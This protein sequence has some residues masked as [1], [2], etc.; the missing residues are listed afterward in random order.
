MSTPPSQA[1]YRVSDIDGL[2]PVLAPAS[3]KRDRIRA[4]VVASAAKLFPI[5]AT[6]FTVTA[7]DI[8]IK[9]SRFRTKDVKSAFMEQRSLT[10]PL[11]A[12]LKITRNDTGETVEE[13]KVTLGHV[14]YLTDEHTFVVDGTRYILSNQLRVRPGAYTRFR[15][16]GELESAFNT[17]KGAS[18]KL[19]ID[20]STGVFYLQFKTTK[21]LLLPVLLALG[22]NDGHIISSWGKGVVE[23]NVRAGTGK[24]LAAL[25]VVA[26][27][28]SPPHAQP[29]PGATREELIAIIKDRWGRAVISPDITQTTLGEAFDHIS[30][31]ALISAG[32][33][34][35]DVYNGRAPEDDRDDVQF[36]TFHMPDTYFKERIEKNLAKSQLGI[37]RTKL[38]RTSQPTIS[39]LGVSGSITAPL[40]SLLTGS[41][42]AQ[43]P[44]QINPL[45][46]IDGA[47]KVTRLGEGGI[48]D[49][50]A[51]NESTRE[52]HDSHLGI[53]DSV[54]TPESGNVGVDVRAA[55]Y[56]SVDERGRMHGV[57]VNA[58]TGQTERVPV[59]VLRR[60][61]IG[62][63]DTDMTKPRVAVLHGDR[64]EEVKPSEVDY[65]CP[66]HIATISPATAFV[67]LPGN[68]QGNR[69]VMGAKQATQA[70]PLVNREEP[71][72]Q[73][74]LG[75]GTSAEKSFAKWHLPVAPAS[76][77]V[78]KIDTAETQIHIKGDDGQMYDVDYADNY[79]LASKTR[80]HHELSVKV[81]D[82]VK[83]DQILGESNF[84]RNGTMALGTNLRTAFLA[85]HGLNSNDAVVISESAANHKLVSEHAYRESLWIG[86]DTTIDKAKHRQYY[87]A[88][89]SPQQYDRLGDDGVIRVGQKVGTGEL[90]VAALTKRQPTADDIMLGRLGRQLT[91]PFKDAALVWDHGHEG[92]VTDVART[93]KGIAVLVM[94]R[95]PMAVGDKLSGRVGNKGVVSKI[96]PDNLMPRGED[97]KPMELLITSAAVVSRI[98]PS[99]VI[100]RAAAKAAQKLGTTV[101]AP[102]YTG[103][104]AAAWARDLQ[105]KAGVKDKE[106]LFDPVTGKSIEKIATGP[107]YVY[108]LFKSTETNF[109]T[110]G[111]GPGYDQNEQPTK[112]GVAGAKSLG[113]MDMLALVAHDARGILSEAATVKGQAND[114]YW[115]NLQLGLPPGPPK[116]SFA[117][118]KFESMLVGAGVD[119]K[120]RGSK[121]QLGPLTD[122]D[123]DR[124]ADHEISNPGVVQV[125]NTKEGV[126][127]VPEKGGLFDPVTTGGLRGT[128]WGKVTLAEVTI[129]PVFETAAKRILDMDTRTFEDILYNQGGQVLKD[130]LNAVD[131][132]ALE[133]TLSA[134]LKQD[135]GKRPEAHVDKIAKRLK[136]VRALLSLGKK[137]GDA[138]M[139][140]KIPVVPP[141]MRGIVQGQGQTLLV[142]DP[143]FLY[144][145][146]M[147]VNDAFK[148]QPAELKEALGSSASRR[149]LQQAV[150]ALVGTGDPVNAKTQARQVQGFL[151][152]VAGVRT[153]KEGFVQSRLIKRRQDLSGRGTIAPDPNLGIDEI[154]IPEEMLWTQMRPFVMR[155]LVNRGYDALAAEKMIQEHHPTARQELMLETQ[156]RPVM[157][158]RAPTLHRY[159]FVAGWA[160]PVPGKTI[161]LSPFYEQLGNADYD[162]DAIQIHVPVTD[163][164]VS[165]AKRMTISNLALS[166]GSKNSVIAAPQH[167]AIIGTFLA[168]EKATDKPA[169]TFDSKASAMKAYYANK[170]KINDPIVVRSPTDSVIT[171]IPSEL[172]SA[173]S[174]H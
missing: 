83:K 125:K 4:Q 41:A 27:K 70:V 140:S 84:T 166:D 148:N 18:F 31:D 8:A 109:A 128:R 151:S 17:D 117:Y 114:T 174:K 36:Q 172:T 171:P 97:G 122:S 33:K 76:G 149:E 38:N 7:S 2:A 44:A 103:V 85:Y 154:G 66:A 141:V 107:L 52:L 118:K 167:E 157:W 74:D 78:T 159:N 80:L 10:E 6:N 20:P 57:F 134:Q 105:K 53:I 169:V 68:N 56:A 86:P 164:A 19:T 90:L 1:D 79:P 11:T 23:A 123:V 173:P 77:I 156:S 95:E 32:K 54:R 62:F 139:I 126:R 37:W 170:L 47:L 28:V 50:R 43:G 108:K 51:I 116:E 65:I 155:R 61:R 46:I 147:L 102:S 162:G 129:N 29:A 59:Q 58:K 165:D 60:S 26:S 150:K 16:N 99:Q 127:V 34:L 71:L 87:G 21:V 160:K 48:G 113:R 55:V 81:G 24:E 115:K 146:L 73:C 3:V 35:L 163:Q 15:G 110:R 96:V 63:P 89:Y 93:S 49:E 106:T 30:V 153:P 64:V 104:N 112:G 9:P 39:G 94:T 13:R 92:E 143:N 75:D 42:L 161:M 100:D 12:K 168:S 133:S 22:A 40:R 131:L 101:V 136:A 132:R 82:R 69:S 138:Y 137:A 145:D 45:D 98:N 121:I 142:S 91:S 72:V 144:R 130:R 135:I 124:L 158:N 14:P 111:D 67:P 25:K 88:R 5:T 119:L 152:Q 120:R